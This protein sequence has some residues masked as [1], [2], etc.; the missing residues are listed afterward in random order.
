MQI[1]A[2]LGFLGAQKRPN[3]RPKCVVTMIP[4][5][6]DQSVAVGTKSSL[7]G[8]SGTPKR[9]ILGQIGPF[10]VPWGPRSGQIPDQSVWLP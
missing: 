5:Q 6:S 10:W 2:L 1:L 3:T 8:L 9:G 4:T 7:R